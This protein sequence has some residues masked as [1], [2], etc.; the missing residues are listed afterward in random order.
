MAVLPARAALT[1]ILKARMTAS[2]AG[3]SGK[4]KAPKPAPEVPTDLAKALKT[5]KPAAATFK[6]LSSYNQRGYVTWIT[7]T[8]KAATRDRRIEQAVEWRAEGKPRNCKYMK[9]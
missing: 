8:K 9:N 4:S 1:K 5:S 7:V 2:E 6:A 3:P